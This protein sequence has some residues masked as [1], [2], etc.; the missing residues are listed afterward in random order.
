MRVSSFP[1]NIPPAGAKPNYPEYMTAYS[2]Q[3]STQSA[4]RSTISHS[5]SA[6]IPC[7]SHSIPDDSGESELSDSFGS[8]QY[9]SSSGSSASS[10]PKGELDLTSFLLSYH[11]I[12]L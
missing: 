2:S 4:A 6:S 5:S 10:D 9:A 8:T 11:L 3:T 12:S 7:A 1:A